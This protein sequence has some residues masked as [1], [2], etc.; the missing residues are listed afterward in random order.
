MSPLLNMM[1]FAQA[2][3]VVHQLAAQGRCNAL[4]VE[5]D[6]II[7]KM[8]VSDAHEQRSLCILQQ[9]IRSFRA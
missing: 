6:A 1:P 3:K 4:R 8:L 5:L 9:Q 7:R 2:L